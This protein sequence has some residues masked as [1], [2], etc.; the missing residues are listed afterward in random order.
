MSAIVDTPRGGENLL[1]LTPDQA[2]E[3]L[4]AFF[5]A[6]GE[7]AY[8]ANQVLAHLWQKPVRGFEDIT[9]LPKAVRE[10][11]ATAF[12]MPRM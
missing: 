7:P 1:N 5:K 11:L 3:R 2:H 12:T 9:S 4:S 10:K 8:R 6:Q